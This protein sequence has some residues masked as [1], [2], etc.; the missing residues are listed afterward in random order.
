MTTLAPK[1]P[2]THPFAG[3]YPRIGGQ[4]LPTD[5]DAIDYLERVKAADGGV[6]VEVGVAMAIEPNEPCRLNKSSNHNPIHR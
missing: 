6:G 1:L 2:Y 5:P 3:G 4:P